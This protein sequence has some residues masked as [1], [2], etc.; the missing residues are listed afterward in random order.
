MQCWRSDWIHF[1]VVVC[2]CMWMCH[3]FNKRDKTCIA[4]HTKYT[5]LC[6]RC[7]LYVC[8]NNKTTSKSDLRVYT[9]KKIII[10]VRARSFDWIVSPFRPVIVMWFRVCVNITYLTCILCSCGMPHMF[11]YHMHCGSCRSVSLS[12]SRIL[13]PIN[14]DYDD[15]IIKHFNVFLTSSPHSNGITSS[16]WTQHIECVRSNVSHAWNV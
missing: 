10:G 4:T 3:G 5:E 7:V 12:L 11:T 6:M 14:F 16:N 8:G 13:K 1:A 9:Q 15:G 2:V